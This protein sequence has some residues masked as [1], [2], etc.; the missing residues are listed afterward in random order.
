[1]LAVMR[2]AADIAGLSPQQVRES[3]RQLARS[4][5][6]KNVPIGKVEDG[7]WPG[8]AGALPYRA[9]YPAQSAQPP[10]PAGPPALVYFHG[11]GGIFGDIDTHDGLCRT[12]AAESGC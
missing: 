2:G 6:I 7:A 5:D 4:V 12:L 1:M 9:Y 11:G 3:F 10:D 8:P